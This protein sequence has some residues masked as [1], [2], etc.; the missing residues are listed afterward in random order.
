[1][2]IAFVGFQFSSGRKI[3]LIRSLAAFTVIIAAMGLVTPVMA[4]AVASLPSAY[5][6]NAALALGGAALLVFGARDLL[7]RRERSEA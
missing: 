7:S 5:L 4:M 3:M 2:F 1:M 6:M